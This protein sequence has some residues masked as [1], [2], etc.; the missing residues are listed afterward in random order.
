MNMQRGTKRITL[1]VSVLA[2]LGVW[3]SFSKAC[4]DDWH[5]ER[6]QYLRYCDKHENLKWFWE[7]WDADG[8]TADG[9]TM[10]KNDVLRY[11]L[12]I[13]SFHRRFTRANVEPDSSTEILLSASEVL[14]GMDL[15]MVDLPPVALADAVQ[16]AREEGLSTA[17]FNR[18]REETFWTRRTDLQLL[19]LSVAFGFL[20]STAAFLVVWLLFFLLRWIGRGFLTV[21]EQA[22]KISELD[23]PVL[24]ARTVPS[25]GTECRSSVSKTPEPAAETEEQPMIT[26]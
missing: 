8:W 4:L 26:G 14:P 22:P 3:V 10:S 6:E 7:A 16:E 12:E 11:L 2:G 1:V 21:A 25:G 17:G 15:A 13:P 23:D 20:P 9:N 5:Y 18:W 24:S 19:A